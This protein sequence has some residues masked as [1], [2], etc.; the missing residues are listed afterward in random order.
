MPISG[1][2]KTSS[3]GNNP[4]INTQYQ[5]QKQG[6]K[7]VA[8]FGVVSSDSPSYSEIGMNVDNYD[9]RQANSAEE[10]LA[11]LAVLG[12]EPPQEVPAH[13]WTPVPVN[14]KLV[15][16]FN[17]TIDPT[18]V[19]STNI[20]VNPAGLPGVDIPGDFT[21]INNV[22]EFQ[23]TIPAWVGGESFV[24]TITPAVKSVQGLSLN[25][26]YIIN[27]N[28]VVVAGFSLDSSDPADGTPDV[29]VDKVIDMVF[30]ENVN[31]ATVNDTNIIVHSVMGGVPVSGSFNT[32]GD[33]V[34]FTPDGLGYAGGDSIQVTITTDVEDTLGNPLAAE[35]TFTFLIEGGMP[36]I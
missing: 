29:P 14:E 17:H 24:V 33:T 2:K 12:S 13:D 11:P 1:R 27:V 21:V 8:K 25:E 3:G 6:K 22:V 15:F 10:S 20:K 9:E 16:T 18:T 28:V 23:T 35:E 19:N 34:S 30:T 32:V 26:D 4:N 7:T 31:A 36:I 5:P